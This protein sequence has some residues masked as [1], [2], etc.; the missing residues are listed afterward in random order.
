VYLSAAGVTTNQIFTHTKT[1]FMSILSQ[2]ILGGFSGKTG[3]V[4]GS[5]WRD[6]PVMRTKPVYKKKTVSM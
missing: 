1:N 2:G 5:F 4:I 6:K 3:P